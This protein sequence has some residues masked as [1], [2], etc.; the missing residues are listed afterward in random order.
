MKVGDAVRLC[1]E[2]AEEHWEG[3]GVVA[4]LVSAL[5]IAT[6]L[7]VAFNVIATRLDVLDHDTAG[8]GRPTHAERA[9]TGDG[10]G[11]NAVMVVSRSLSKK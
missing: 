9:E 3:V 11:H 6:T 10:S 8:A 7:A 1:L 2:W 5:T 4:S